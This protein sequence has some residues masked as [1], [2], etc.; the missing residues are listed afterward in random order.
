MA[1]FQ[2][3]KKQRKVLK[4]FKSHNLGLQIDR[5]LVCSY[6]LVQ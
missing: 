5:E 2:H 1:N 3:F 6:V 4:L